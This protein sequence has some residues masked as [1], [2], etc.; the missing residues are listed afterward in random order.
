[1]DVLSS[2]QVN[3]GSRNTSVLFF[4]PLSIGSIVK[5]SNFPILN[6]VA[7]HNNA[8]YLILYDHLLEL[9]LSM[10][11]W[12]LGN[13]QLPSLRERNPIRI[14]VVLSLLFMELDSTVL[15]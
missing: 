2:C 15:V 12:A 4:L 7:K 14:D 9:V 1:M 11:E 3:F 8:L 6:N 5:T 13:D 10:F